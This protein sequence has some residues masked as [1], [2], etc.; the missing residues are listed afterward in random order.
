LVLKALSTP[1]LR[2][3]PVLTMPRP[4]PPL[5]SD[6]STQRTPSF[7][8]LAAYLM[9]QSAVPL[10]LSAPQPLSW[11]GVTNSLL[12]LFPPQDHSLKT[13]VCL[14]ESWPP[15]GLNLLIPV[16][17]PYYAFPHRAL[18]LSI[19]PSLAGCR[20]FLVFFLFFF[21]SRRLKSRAQPPA[22]PLPRSVTPA[23]SP[24]PFRPPSL[25]YVL[26]SMTRSHPTAQNFNSPSS[27]FPRPFP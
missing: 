25:V 13:H 8:Q 23:A 9:N 19:F 1:F 11:R 15:R 16:P 7:S 21:P 10:I 27:H 18:R 5:R 20:P 12:S 17:S 26:M 4:H 6:G 2:S 24:T 14:R 22:P 3:T